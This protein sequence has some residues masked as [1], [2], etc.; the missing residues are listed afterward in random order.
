MG[1]NLIEIERG[2][3]K[4][5]VHVRLQAHVDREKPGMYVSYCPA[6]DLYSQGATVKEARANI[7]EAVQLFI[8]S[9]FE[10]GTLRD[11]LLEC[12]FRLTGGK[13]P[14]GRIPA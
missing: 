6:L 9:C 12:G 10:R 2:A 13:L 4:V 11:V 14:F 5:S 3:N 1:S 8:E 7:A